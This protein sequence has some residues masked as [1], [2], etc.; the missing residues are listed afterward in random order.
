[1][2]GPTIDTFLTYE[3]AKLMKELGYDEQT[4]FFYSK[5]FVDDGTPVIVHKGF[6]ISYRNSEMNAIDPDQISAPTQSQA[7]RWLRHRKL[8]VQV[9]YNVGKD[10]WY[11]SVVEMK[12]GYNVFSKF[13][14][15]T[16]EDAMAGGIS[17]AINELNKN[18]H[19]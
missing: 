11:C 2:N 5:T 7:T 17:A 16:Y 6:V 18:L 14:Y 12:N 15:K 4:Y 9:S 3:Q 13:G 8:S 19:I 1:M 10:D